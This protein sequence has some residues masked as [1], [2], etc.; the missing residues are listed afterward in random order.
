MNIKKCI[1]PAPKWP[2]FLKLPQTENG[3]LYF[4][5]TFQKV[6]LRNS[7]FFQQYFTNRAKKSVFD[8]DGTR[9]K[10]QEQNSKFWDRASPIIVHHWPCSWQDRLVTQILIDWVMSMHMNS[11]FS[12]TLQLAR[13][14]SNTNIDWLCYEHAPPLSAI[15][16]LVHDRTG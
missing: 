12:L 16:D 2:N 10:R 6:E 9:K 3:K 7:T 13:H 15:T 4:S 11:P 1:I 8:C 5:P 14:V